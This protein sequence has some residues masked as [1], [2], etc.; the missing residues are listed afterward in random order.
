VTCGLLSISK[1]VRLVIAVAINYMVWSI[2]RDTTRISIATLKDVR[3][4]LV[5]ISKGRQNSYSVFS[6]VTWYGLFTV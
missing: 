5:L 2:L 6:S 4:K 1:A 3:Q